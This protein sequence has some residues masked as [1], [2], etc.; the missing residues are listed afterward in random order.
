M[1]F[2]PNFYYFKPTESLNTSKW[3]Y[4]S[5]LLRF[6]NYYWLQMYLNL[7]LSIHMNINIYLTF[8][9]IHSFVCKNKIMTYYSFM[10]C[11]TTLE[12]WRN[13][14][15]KNNWENILM[16]ELT[17][18]P[19]ECLWIL[20]KSQNQRYFQKFWEAFLDAWRCH[21]HGQGKLQEKLVL[22]LRH[23]LPAIPV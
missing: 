11:N 23:R 20:R 13:S 6:D 10:L 16:S 3:P 5:L 19:D 2:S 15:C 4:S 22:I 1:A 14:L 8:F 9:S 12:D 7:S 18:F 17:E 21:L